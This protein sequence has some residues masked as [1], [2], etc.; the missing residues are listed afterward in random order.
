MK[1]ELVLER[2]VTV[3]SEVLEHGVTVTSEVLEHGFTV[4]SDG[5]GTRGYG[6]LR[7]FWNT[8]LR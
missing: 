5:S 8:G 3:T 4:T 7:R 2:R 6:D 1:V